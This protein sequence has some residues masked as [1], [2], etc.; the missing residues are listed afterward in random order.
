MA[1]TPQ[2]DGKPVSLSA[3]ASPDKLESGGKNIFANQ[4]KTAFAP[5]PVS[6]A[7]APL[8]ANSAPAVRPSVRVTSSRQANNQNA[9]NT[10]SFLMPGARAAGDDNKTAD[11]TKTAASPATKRAAPAS[12]K[13]SATLPVASPEK[14]SP[15]PAAPAAPRQPAKPAGPITQVDALG[16]QGKLPVFVG[17]ASD[18]NPMIDA[19]NARFT[20]DPFGNSVRLEFCVNSVMLKAACLHL[21][22]PQPERGPRRYLFSARMP[23]PRVEKHREKLF[24]GNLEIRLSAIED[25]HPVLLDLTLYED[26]QVAPEPP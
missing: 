17:R 16:Y 12:S 21:G 14:P 24:D 18:G 10:G 2:K 23:A 6:R 22:I 13:G 15:A 20:F 25:G 26:Y 3:P 9:A 19:E 7:R 1:Q 5:T 11:E 4:P 8:V